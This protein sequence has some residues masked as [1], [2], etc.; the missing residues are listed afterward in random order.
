MA[1]QPKAATA[2][3]AQKD[4]SM[5]LQKAMINKN[6]E[7][8]AH[9]HEEN[10]KVF[11]TFVPGNINELLMCFDLIGNYPEINAIQNGMRKKSGRYIM[12]AEK[13]G[14]SE[15]VCTYVKTDIGMVQIGR[16][17]V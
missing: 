1:D 3:E 5:A 8:L 6:Y 2:T 9:A 15:D 4:Q 17:H 16:A 12:E 13:A 11:Y 7:R 14:H 10:R